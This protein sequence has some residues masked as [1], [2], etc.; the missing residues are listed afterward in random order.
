MSNQITFNPIYIRSIET[1]KNNCTVYTS[2]KVYGGG[3][4]DKK[5]SFNREDD[6]SNYESCMRIKKYFDDTYK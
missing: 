2:R 6:I 3:D 4:I 5:Y 1:Y